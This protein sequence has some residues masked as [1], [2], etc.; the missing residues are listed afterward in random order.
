MSGLSARITRPAVAA[1]SYRVG[2]AATARER[3]G[4]A[5]RVV[6]QLALGSYA[7][8]VDFVARAAVG[9]VPRTVRADAP[10]FLIPTG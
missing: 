6:I 1:G 4:V 10:A 5:L 2:G 9:V 3:R 7:A 8:G